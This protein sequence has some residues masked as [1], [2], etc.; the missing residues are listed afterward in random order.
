MFRTPTHETIPVWYEIGATDHTKLQISIHP[1]AA[2]HI[3]SGRLEKSPRVSDT[4]KENK[5]FISFIPPTHEKWGFGEILH[6]SFNLRR[7]EWLTFDCPLPTRD[8]DTTWAVRHT[9]DLLF[10]YLSIFEDITDSS[11]PQLLVIEGM[12]IKADLHGGALGASVTPAL[13]SWIAALPQNQDLTEISTAMY[14]AHAHMFP[15]TKRSR[16][17]KHEFQANSW[18]NK[19]YLR[20]C[21]NACDLGTDGS[22]RYEPGYGY[23]MSPHNVDS[24]LQQ[25][26]LLMGLAKTHDLARAATPPT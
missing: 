5:K 11:E 15:A 24:G 16:L 21:G 19:L 25:L 26:S 18:S 14:D 8:E 4:L 6:A 13:A 12:A 7:M 3:L 23:C 20:V 10:S 2:C 22:S 17:Y 9:L 1:D